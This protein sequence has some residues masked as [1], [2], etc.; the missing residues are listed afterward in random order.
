MW[1]LST[2]R[3]TTPHST[4]QHGKSN[5]EISPPKV[6][7]EFRT[8]PHR[9]FR[10]PRSQHQKEQLPAKGRLTVHISS[11]AEVKISSMEAFLRISVTESSQ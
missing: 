2:A 4:A 3:V 9:S 11:T 1:S 10:V 6:Y 5:N 7:F 8:S